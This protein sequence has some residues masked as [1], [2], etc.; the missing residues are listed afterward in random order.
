MACGV[1]TQRTTLFIQSQVH[2]HS[3]LSRLLGAITPVGTLR[4]MVQFKEK[5]E[6]QGQD[7]S[8]GL[9]DYPVLMAADI[10]L[11]DADVVPVGAD[12][13]QHLELTADIADRFNR[14][15]GPT[16]KM[17]VPLV[18]PETAKIMSLTDGTKK[19]S[20]SD[21]NDASRINLLDP[22]D[23]VRLK[24]KRA[25]SDATRGLEY[26]NSV[27]PEAHN[28]LT[29]YQVLA[30]KTRQDALKECSQMGFGQFKPLLAE[31]IIN[32]LMPIQ[33]KYSELMKDKPGLMSV[34]KDGKERALAV[35]EKT[36]FRAQ[37]AMGFVS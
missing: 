22:P 10:L 24:I 29:I 13:K 1:D 5:A 12:Q 19:M 16:L 32:A 26:D 35:A 23:V 17:P 34:L 20:K 30:G 18:V 15:Y 9:L 33:A 4:R 36:L 3:Q 27:R 31:T 14:L 28:L 21:P 7:A 6:R 37:E 8:L 25:K 11:Y 2:Q